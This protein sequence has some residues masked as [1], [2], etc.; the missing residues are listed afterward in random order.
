MQKVWM[1]WKTVDFGQDWLEGVFDSE[2]KAN[3]AKATMFADWL[4]E[5]GMTLAQWQMK[6][7]KDQWG[8]VDDPFFV[9]DEVVK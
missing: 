5:R 6:K 8:E 1:V 2:A 9:T 7:A 3:I 4:S